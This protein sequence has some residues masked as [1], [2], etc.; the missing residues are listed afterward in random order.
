MLSCKGFVNSRFTSNTY[1]I[2]SSQ[3]DNVWLVDPGDT[4]VVF[5]WMKNHS[6][7]I[8][9]GIFLTGAASE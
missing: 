4:E 9:S 3:Y 5:E 1:I 2:S 7:T 6:K 8:V